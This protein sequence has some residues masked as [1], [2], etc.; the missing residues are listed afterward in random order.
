MSIYLTRRD[1]LQG[2]PTLDPVTQWR[3]NVKARLRLEF[4]FHRVTGNIDV[5]EQQWAQEELLCRVLGVQKSI[6]LEKCFHMGKP[7]FDSDQGCIDKRKKNFSFEDL[8]CCTLC[9]LSSFVLLFS[10]GPLAS[11]FL[12]QSPLQFP[13]HLF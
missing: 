5:F 12:P 2:G 10:F 6:K 13:W 3:Y 8:F 1:R 11:S 9:F 7:F 4:C